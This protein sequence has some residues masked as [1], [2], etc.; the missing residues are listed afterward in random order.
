[1]NK[2]QTSAFWLLV[3]AF[4]RKTKF[5][6]GAALCDA[7]T[8]LGTATDYKPAINYGY[9]THV[10]PERNKKHAEWWKL[11]LAGAA[12][13]QDFIDYEFFFDDDMKIRVRHSADW[14]DETCYDRMMEIF[15]NHHAK[16]YPTP[17]AC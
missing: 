13:V 2:T 8:G 5:H 11:T 1:M 10:F 16:H 6:Q 3:E 17:S 9:M 4:R 14:G 7:W 15:K 12:I